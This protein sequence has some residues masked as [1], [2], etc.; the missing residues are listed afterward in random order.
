MLFKEQLWYKNRIQKP[1][2]L[3]ADLRTKKPEIAE[4][5]VAWYLA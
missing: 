3:A 4:E 2:Q 5:V 1:H